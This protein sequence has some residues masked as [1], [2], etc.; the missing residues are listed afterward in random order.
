MSIDSVRREADKWTAQERWPS[1]VDALMDR[2]H[3]LEE[4]NL[5]RRFVELLQDLGRKGRLSREDAAEVAIIADEIK[6]R[7]PTGTH[8]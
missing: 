6:V 8:T 7:Y 1:M 2:L 3:N 4:G 5:Q